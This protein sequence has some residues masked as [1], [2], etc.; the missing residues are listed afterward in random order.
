M[1]GKSTTNVA[2]MQPTI[3]RLPAGMMKGDKSTE[4]FANRDSKKLFAISNGKSIPFNKLPKEM[5]AQ[6]FA[7]LLDDPK[8]M[9][10][11]KH[12]SATDATQQY[13]FCLYGTA[14]S[15]PDF[16]QNG[17]LKQPDNFICSNNC[18]CL[19]WQSKAIMLNGSRLTIR[20][21]EIIQLLA[22]DKSD[23][24]IADELGISISTLDTHK[25]HL[26][27]KAGVFS[28]PGLI[29]AAIDEKIIQ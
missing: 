5:R 21:I 26:F 25:T 7:K 16:C 23:K 3:H 15:N 8:A 12:L 18:Q 2:T 17:E 9:E 27:E 22:T 4:I 24:M 29:V 10:D 11:L 13:A 1:Y 14:D 28:K 20:E 19:K 6:I